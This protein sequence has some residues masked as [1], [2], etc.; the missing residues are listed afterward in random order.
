MT[1][2]VSVALLLLGTVLG[3]FGTGVWWVR[4]TSK[5]EV[6]KEML[7]SLYLKAHPHWLQVSASDAAPVCPVCGWSEPKHHH[8]PAPPAEVLFSETEK[9]EGT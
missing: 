7:R 9:R 4:H 8:E 5:P 2:F 6:A 1:L 3:A